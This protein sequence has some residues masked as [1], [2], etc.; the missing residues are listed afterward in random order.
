MRKYGR[1]DRNQD[2]IVSALRKCGASVTSLS[3]VGGGCPDLLVG[4]RGRTYVIEAKVG[5]NWLTDDQIKW[6]NE[7]NGKGF[8]VNSPEQALVG[9]GAINGKQKTS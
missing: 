8:I 1:T 3:A 6:W 4:F 7:F 5:K 2:A 9:I